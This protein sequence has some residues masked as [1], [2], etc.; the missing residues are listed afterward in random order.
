MTEY[1]NS[2]RLGPREIK[3][4]RAGTMALKK[5]LAYR[6]KVELKHDFLFSTKNG[7]KMSKST[8]G[9]GLQATTSK[10]LGKK[11]GSR[12][13][14]ILHASDKENREAIEKSSELTK[15]LLHTAAQTKQ[16]VRK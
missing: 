15:K 6:D 2:D 9:K 13:I 11:I 7:D 3:I 14:R 8:F 1:K 16:Y 5:F 12:I 10:I 4:S